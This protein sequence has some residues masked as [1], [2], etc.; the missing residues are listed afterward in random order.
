MIKMGMSN[1]EF[2]QQYEV[3]KNLGRDPSV[4]GFS[5]FVEAQ[6][7]QA[8]IDWLIK[9][10]FEG[11]EFGWGF[12]L[13][14]FDGAYDYAVQEWLDTPEEEDEPEPPV[15]EI[16]PPEVTRSEERRVGKECPV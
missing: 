6:Y 3:W 5:N 11:T 2:A 8:R 10:H 1:V 7:N 13:D 4:Q 9:N 14:V 16:E 15:E 12:V